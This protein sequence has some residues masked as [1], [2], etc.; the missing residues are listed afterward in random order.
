MSAA[1]AML[2]T[3]RSI[4]LEARERALEAA[5]RFDPDR[6]PLSLIE[7]F[8]IRCWAR[9][10][11][12]TA[13]KM[14]FHEAVDSLQEAAVDNGLVEQIGQDQVQAIMA[15]AFDGVSYAA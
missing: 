4:Y 7:A 11:L 1:A 14:D 13:G 10:Y 8:D 6:R 9:A 5:Q 15:A 2:A 12:V 3:G